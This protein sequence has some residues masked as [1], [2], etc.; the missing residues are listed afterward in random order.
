MKTLNF[1]TVFPLLASFKVINLQTSPTERSNFSAIFVPKIIEL[2]FSNEIEPSIIF[3]RFLAFSLL[4]RKSFSIARI[5]PPLLPFLPI[6]KPCPSRCTQAFTKYG[7][8]TS[9]LILAFKASSFSQLG[10]Y[11]E[12]WASITCTCPEPSSIVRVA[13]PEIIPSETTNT[14]TSGIILIPIPK[15]APKRLRRALE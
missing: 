8:F 7:S 4:E 3:I 12:G 14:T 11:K 10:K 5:T 13:I 9:F 6:S 1:G 2:S 15:L